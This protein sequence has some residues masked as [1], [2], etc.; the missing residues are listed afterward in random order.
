MKS[1]SCNKIFCFQIAA[2]FHFCKVASHSSTVQGWVWYSYNKHSGLL[3]RLIIVSEE[4]WGE[5]SVTWWQGSRW[6]TVRLVCWFWRDLQMEPS[7]DCGHSFPDTPL[8]VRGWERER[9][10]VIKELSL[11]L[12]LR[13][14]SGEDILQFRLSVLSSTVWPAGRGSPPHLPPP[15]PLLPHQTL[16]SLHQVCMILHPHYL[17]SI[18]PNAWLAGHQVVC[19]VYCY[20]FL[21]L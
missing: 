10:K 3:V 17:S 14:R 16:S 5:G 9:E 11:S 19:H 18:P 4:R 2:I 20:P 6:E 8:K 7:L 12:I 1:P 21:V 13:R 15:L